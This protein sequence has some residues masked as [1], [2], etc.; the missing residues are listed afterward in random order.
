MDKALVLILT[1]VMAVPTQAI[2]QSL[3]SSAD[4][5]LLAA[6]MAEAATSFLEVPARERRA[7]HGT[8]C[9]GYRGGRVW[10][11]SLPTGKT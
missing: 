5:P 3:P 9:R 1:A 7:P 6:A 8:E 11:L 2:A 4:R 10:I